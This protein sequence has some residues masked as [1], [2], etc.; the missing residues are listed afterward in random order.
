M[1]LTNLLNERRGVRMWSIK[2]HSN[3]CPNYNRLRVM[4]DRRK[5]GR[6]RGLKN[7]KFVRFLINLHAK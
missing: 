6:Q 7:T 2:K 5:M 4:A 1:N 3:P